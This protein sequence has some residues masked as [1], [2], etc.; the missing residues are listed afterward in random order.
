MG[1]KQKSRDIRAL[2]A[3]GAKDYIMKLLLAKK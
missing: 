3:F 1:H 2:A